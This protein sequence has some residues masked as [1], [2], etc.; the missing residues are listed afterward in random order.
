MRQIQRGPH[1]ADCEGLVALKSLVVPLTQ[2]LL[3]VGPSDLAGGDLASEE[4]LPLLPNSFF[5]LSGSLTF[6]ITLIRLGLAHILGA[7]HNHDPLRLLSRR[8]ENGVF[9]SIF[10]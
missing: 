4:K 8:L 5:L 9:P 6:I 1:S 7:G 2:H 3:E 10:F